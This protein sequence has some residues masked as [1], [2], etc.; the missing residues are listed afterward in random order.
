MTDSKSSSSFMDTFVLSSANGKKNQYQRPESTAIDKTQRYQGEDEI[1]EVRNRSKTT[2]TTP[3]TPI[4]KPTLP[5][6][7]SSSCDTQYNLK[8][9]MLANEH[10]RCKQQ[11]RKDIEAKRTPIR[12][13]KMKPSRT[14]NTGDM[15]PLEENVRIITIDDILN[16]ESL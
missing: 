7:G 9:Q 16:E 2:T 6:T 14:H 1:K 15:D 13:V 12:D 4:R 3:T 10:D 8:M 5:I 11:E